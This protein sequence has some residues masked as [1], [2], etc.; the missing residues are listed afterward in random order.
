MA[1]TFVTIVLNQT[2]ETAVLRRFFIFEWVCVFPFSQIFCQVMGV[3]C[4]SLSFGY[5]VPFSSSENV[6]NHQLESQARK[7]VHLCQH[8]Q[9]RKPHHLY[10]PD[11][12]IQFFVLR[13]KL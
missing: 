11:D 8:G 4:V 6:D 3:L 13:D 2:E 5:N 10:H 9:L 12:S 7:N 1:I